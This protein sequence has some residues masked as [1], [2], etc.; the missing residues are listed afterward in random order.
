MTIGIAVACE[1]GVVFACDGR[2]TSASSVEACTC[3]KIENWGTKQ[4]PLWVICAGDNGSLHKIQYEEKPVTV[5]ALAKC[6]RSLDEDDG[7]AEFLAYQGGQAYCID[8]GGG[9]MHV[10][11]YAMIG[12]GAEQSKA[13]MSYVDAE[14]RLV[15][16]EH[17]ARALT[18]DVMPFVAAVNPTCGPPY[19]T[20]VF[21]ASK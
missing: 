19:F 12:R 10:N 2:L 4:K 13:L 15:I 3:N 8:G 7:T 16:A 14:S 1:D 11:A 20:K 6:V 21:R 18:E 17:A 5:D 9:V